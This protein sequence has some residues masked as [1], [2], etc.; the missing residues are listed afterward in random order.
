MASFNNYMRTAVIFLVIVSISALQ[1]ACSKDQTEHTVIHR[2]YFVDSSTV[3]IIISKYK[4]GDGVWIFGNEH[5][6][7]YYQKVMYYSMKTRSLVE[8]NVLGHRDPF[9]PSYAISDSIIVNTYDMNG[10]FSDSLSCYSLDG[11]RIIEIP[12][13]AGIDKSNPYV[14]GISPDSRYI[15][16]SEYV[17]GNQ[18]TSNGIRYDRKTNTFGSAISL[19]ADLKLLSMENDGDHY[20]G[21]R[22]SY[23][24]PF[25][26]KRTLSSQATV[27]TLF[28]S[29]Q[30]LI[31]MGRNN[32]F[33]FKDYNGNAGYFSIDTSLSKATFT[34]LGLNG[35][36]E[37]LD[38]LTGAYLSITNGSLYL[39]NYRSKTSGVILSP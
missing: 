9:A 18:K 36:V 11:R 27:A 1:L 39:G 28:T 14:G 3:G 35:N 10:G 5:P 37:D 8:K 16:I 29:E 30:T 12:V 15:L 23:E 2:A 31:L 20:I 38:T 6:F 21:C 22:Q 25:Y 24:T 17:F 13:P 4:G 34:T 7:D 19:P 26:L 33:I 32:R